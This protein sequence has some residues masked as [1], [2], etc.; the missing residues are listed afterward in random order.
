M[1]VRC[2]IH[3]AA[4]I[5]LLSLA[6]ATSGAA[7]VPRGQM[8]YE[9]HCRQC[10]GSVAHTRSDRKVRSLEGLE[11]M[12]WRW[13]EVLELEWTAAE[14]AAVVDYLNQRFYHF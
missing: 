5:L 13:Q 1:A 3:R 10:H 14:V 9:N 8:L 12:V 11:R 2:K 6:T 7:E 4:P